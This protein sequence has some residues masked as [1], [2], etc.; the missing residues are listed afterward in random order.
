[1][2]DLWKQRDD[3]IKENTDY[4][5]KNQHLDE[6]LR[7]VK[8]WEEGFTLAG[9]LF[10]VSFRNKNSPTTF[11]RYKDSLEKIE[12]DQKKEIEKLKQEMKVKDDKIEYQ[13]KEIK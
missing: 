11:Y 1:M 2:K 12:K 9:I 10:Q 4:E 5:V 6:E 3:L 13:T 7:L 8:R